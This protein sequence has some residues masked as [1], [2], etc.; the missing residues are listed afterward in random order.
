[1]INSQNKYD[2]LLSFRGVDTRDNFTSHLYFALCQKSSETFIDDQLIRGNEI[3]QSLLYTIEA[4][5]TSIIISSERYGFQD[6]VSMN[7]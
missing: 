6:G 7:F 5:G 3:S 4:L 2:V 1:M